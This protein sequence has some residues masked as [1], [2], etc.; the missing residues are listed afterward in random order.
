MK[1]KALS[2]II[3]IAIYYTVNIVFGKTPSLKSNKS[4]QREID[5]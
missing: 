1:V 3:Y 4:Y 5:L 2:T